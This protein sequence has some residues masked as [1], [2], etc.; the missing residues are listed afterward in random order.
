MVSQLS[1]G[2]LC[3]LTNSNFI[4]VDDEY[5]YSD[6]DDQDTFG[7]DDVDNTRSSAWEGDS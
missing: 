3:Y 4:Q 2:K 5:L 6:E 1:I 7:I